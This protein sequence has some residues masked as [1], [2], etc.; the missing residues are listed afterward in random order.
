MGD[1]LQSASPASSRQINLLQHYR[2]PWF[3]HQGL[4]YDHNSLAAI[5]R[6][7][8]RRGLLSNLA[9]LALSAT[10]VGPIISRLGGWD[11]LDSDPWNMGHWKLVDR[12]WS[13][14]NNCR[15]SSGV[16]LVAWQIRTGGCCQYSRILSCFWHGSNLGHSC[17][18][19]T[20]HYHRTTDSSHYQRPSAYI[21]SYP[22]GAR[23]LE[24][25]DSYVDFADGGN[26]NSLNPQILT[27]IMTVLV[28]YL[29]QC[30]LKR[31]KQTLLSP[32]LV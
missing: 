2:S 24:Y 23:N 19:D 10:A 30:S 21:S 28:A 29:G 5:D 31:M 7:L 17:R 15:D 9:R 14:S 20:A 11:S 6:G 16:S 18:W 25:G 26:A 12:S 32:N 27:R 22:A 8:V 13:R 4:L 3:S 1:S